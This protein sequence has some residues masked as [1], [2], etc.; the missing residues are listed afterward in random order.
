LDFDL[1][2]HETDIVGYPILPLVHQLVKQC[3][4]AGGYVHWGVRR[5]AT[6]TGSW[7]GS[8]IAVSRGWSEDHLRASTTFSR[9]P[10]NSSF[11]S[12]SFSA[13]ISNAT[14]YGRKLVTA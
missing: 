4:E 14:S 10:S 9:R 12:P 13:L 11:L 7:P 6:E 8:A 1:L 5:S 3:G 2:R